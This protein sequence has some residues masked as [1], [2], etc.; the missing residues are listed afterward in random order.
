MRTSLALVGLL[1]AAQ[2]LHAQR[3]RAV[4]G[5]L[6]GTGT[7]AYP[8]SGLYYWQENPLIGSMAAGVGPLQGVEPFGNDLAYDPKHKLLF[9]VGGGVL[10][11]LGRLR[12]CAGC[13]A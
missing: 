12:L 2:L 13:V 3:I 4:F 1:W 11:K 6:E 7:S 8:H 5:L 10:R 9:L